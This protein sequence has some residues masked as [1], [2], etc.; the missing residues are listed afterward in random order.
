MNTTIS[1]LVISFV[2]ANPDSSINTICE[3]MRLDHR[4]VYTAL[5]S[6]IELDIVSCRR[7]G[8]ENRYSIIP[9]ACLDEACP[10]M[11]RTVIKDVERKAEALCCRGWP[12]RAATFLT[13]SLHLA[14]TES[15]IRRLAGLRNQYLKMAKRPRHGGVE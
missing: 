13:D 5:K 6:L 14:S 11:R 3:L 9:G 12:R 1:E 8:R 15:D 2:Q 7:Q 4:T 10:S